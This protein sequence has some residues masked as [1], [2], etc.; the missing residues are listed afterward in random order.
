MTLKAGEVVLGRYEVESLLEASLQEQRYAAVHTRLGTAAE[1]RLFVGGTSTEGMAR[2]QR[3]AAVMSEVRHANVLAVL[4]HGVHQGRPCTVTEAWRGETLAAALVRQG[5]PPWWTALDVADQVLDGLEAI[6]DAGVVH[7]GITPS[8]LVL[9]DADE[10]VKVVDW[11]L[12]K[13]TDGRDAGVTQI[14][15]TVGSPLYMAPE[16]IRAHPATARADI[17]AVGLVL[18]EALTGALPEGGRRP[19]DTVKRLS[20]PAP[21]PTPPKGLPP[22]PASV[23]RALCRA[24]AIEPK[25]RIASARAFRKALLAAR[26][27]A[28]APADLPGFD[29]AEAESAALGTASAERRS[30]TF[31]RLR[32]AMGGH[33]P[34]PPTSAPPG[35]PEPGPEPRLRA[36]HAWSAMAARGALRAARGPRDSAARALVAFRP[37]A[38]SR[39]PA[40]R[41]AV[42]P[43]GEVIEL[44]ERA[45]IALLSAGSLD[46]LRAALRD[47]PED[48]ALAWREVSPSFALSPATREGTAPPPHV[49]LHLIERLYEGDDAAQGET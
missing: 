20:I 18:Y 24:L 8:A 43:Q 14:G 34:L 35:Q 26:A 32:A 25:R 9:D 10:G 48:V 15:G 33:A 44:G 37:P 4:E 46:R 12:A 31:R 36:A 39:V 13:A 5:A 38:E 47:G 7:R 22:I 21:P 28:A 19:S 1:L 3:A 11:S 6:H 30:R 2:F 45:W 40:V 42:G 17:Y 27:A 29:P 49:A 16:Q 41:D 23:G